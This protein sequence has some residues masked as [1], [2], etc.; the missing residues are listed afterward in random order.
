M[1]YQQCN[2]YRTSLDFDHEYLW[3]GA[4]NRQVENGVIS[5]DFSTFD[6]KQF[7]KLWSTNEKRI[8]TFDL[9]IQWVR[10]VLTVHAHAKF[11]QAKC[12]GS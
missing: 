5:Y 10:A 11:R 2:K 4:R 9:D 8:L 3:N 1:S 12:S 7:N 6:K